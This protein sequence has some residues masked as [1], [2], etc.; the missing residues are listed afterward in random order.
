[1]R[2][3]DQHVPADHHAGG[4]LLADDVEQL[5][6]VFDSQAVLPWTEPG[7]R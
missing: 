1:V 2:A 3:F 7:R 5:S 4:Y 6:C